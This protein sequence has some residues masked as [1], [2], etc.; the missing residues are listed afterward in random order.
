[1]TDEDDSIHGYLLL[2]AAVLVATLVGSWLL[3]L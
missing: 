1:M 2:M 3:F